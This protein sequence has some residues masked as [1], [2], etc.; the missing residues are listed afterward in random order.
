MMV[1]QQTRH[2]FVFFDAQ[3]R[4]EWV[5][6]AFEDLTG[7]LL[8]DIVGQRPEDF[9]SCPQ[10]NPQT[11]QRVI[12]AMKAGQPVR[13][14]LLHQS[15]E[16]RRHWVDMD[17]QPVHDEQGQVIGFISVELEVTEQVSLRKR[18]TAVF[19]SAACGLLIYD[20]AGYIVDCNPEA[21]VILGLE[22][23]E[24]V[25]LWLGPAHWQLLRDDG[26]E[27][28]PEDHPVLSTLRSGQALRDLR[29]GQR[30]D[31]GTEHW[32]LLHTQLLEPEGDTQRGVILSFIDV[33]ERRQQEEQLK[34]AHTQAQQALNQLGA[35]RTALDE[36][37]AVS[38][39]D[40]QGQITFV[41]T[42]FCEISG[43]SMN[44]LLGQNHRLLRT[45]L[46]PP[47]YF[48]DLWNTISQG[49]TWTGEI[50]NRSR[51]GK[52]YWVDTT[53]VP[54][55]DPQGQIH[56]YVAISYD[57]TPH[58]L[59]LRQLRESRER[60]KSLLAMS[61]DWYWEQDSQLRFT[62][63]S[64]GILQ[65]GLDREAFIGKRQWDLDVDLE[66]ASW[67]QHRA[68]VE[69]HQPY[70]NF[71]Y[72]IRDPQDPS[73]WMW[74]G[75]SGQPMVDAQGRFTG[76]RG[77]GRDVTS[78]R[79]AQE[80]LWQLANLDPLTG[81]PNRMKF[82]SALE[83]AVAESQQLQT[84]FALAI[85]DLDNFKEV[86]DSLG[87]DAGDELLS[88]VAQRLR[89]ALRQSDLIA[90]LGGDE[91]GVIIHGIGS[92]QSISRPLDA[93][94]KAMNE[95]MVIAGQKRRCTLSMGVTLFPADAWEGGNLIKNADI[96]LYRAKAAGRSQYVM[97]QPELKTAVERH[98]S[99]LQELEEAI[100]LEQ[101]ALYY[102][103]VVDVRKGRVV[104]LEA[105]LR[106]HHP[107]HG[108]VSA[109]QFPQVF[110]NMDIASR[111]GRVVTDLALGQ[112]ATWNQQGIQFGKVAI[113]V[114]AADFV[115][116]NFPARLAQALAGAELSPSQ[117]CVEV[118]EGM[119]LGRTARAVLEGLKQ[120][121]ELGVEIAFDDFGTGYA[122]LMHL[123]MPIDRLKIDRSFV[124]DIDKDPV[125]AAI[126]RAVAQLGHSLGK[127]ITVEGVETLEQIQLLGEM[128][129]H[130]F[131]GYLLSRPIPAQEVPIFI[132]GLNLPADFVR[133]TTPATLP[134]R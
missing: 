29:I 118:T 34:A 26:S 101:L 53:V 4:I 44:E 18:L 9:L 123:K 70:R 131:Q 51:P 106:W 2:I 91:F 109:G 117:V 75:M 100:K 72:R 28:S 6:P 120:L 17:I 12:A 32:H 8:A 84:P 41:N 128:G 33:T 37:S 65:T 43:Y 92:G 122:S 80:E 119:F 16:G 38:V 93:M 110:E 24:L 56:Q 48:A 77:V 60:F 81:L 130:Q 11:Q 90:R 30:R 124:I 23:P 57:V 111:I 36:H 42:R 54:I 86:N 61:S 46:N 27:L 58:K 102:Q 59:A 121:H 115:L 35:Y 20:N 22:R 52:H 108:L 87:H 133:H 78:R 66:D 5:N 97:F 50:C 132:A 85:I 98:A 40:S 62:L 107:K 71:E 47:G 95:P 73:R 19:D 67:A 76:Y 134:K 3:R 105:L 64:E 83:H 14:E 112:I 49:Q 39:T 129:C 45:D 96:A 10:T 126:V 15:R 127:H 7:Y 116:G 89:A 13:A 82:N 113:N 94:M 69:Q 63:V 25:G 21:Q 99:L 55:R 31:N 88:T 79:S 1:S 104:S 114:T 103:P 74:F 68:T 125:N